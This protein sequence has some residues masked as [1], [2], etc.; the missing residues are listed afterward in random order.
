MQTE[1]PQGYKRNAR[2]DLVT[3]ENIAPIDLMRDDIVH[4]I[5]A[6]S[7]EVQGR[8]RKLKA[9][10]FEDISAFIDLSAEKY[11]VEMGGAKGN[12][13]LTSFDGKYRV[14]RAN[15][16]EISFDERLQ[17]AKALIDECVREWSKSSH[18][19]LV[20]L[21]ND[22]FRTDK[23]GEL[24]ASRVLGLR[25][26]DINDPRWKRAMEAISDSL[27]VVGNRSYVR[28]YERIGETDKYK[29]IPLDMAGV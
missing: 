13:T 2:G 5:V 7:H 25:R 26:H 4:E 18:P 14:V 19:G 24:R 8:L 22:A 16:D 20:A 10:I 6:K 17:A 1:I 9:E 23:Q 27:Q 28:V 3:L 21:V 29:Q 11:G 12:V 15:A